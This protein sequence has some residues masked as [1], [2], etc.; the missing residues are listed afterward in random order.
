[1]KKFQNLPFVLTLLILA[2]FSSIAFSQTAFPNSQIAS[3]QMAS[4]SG[5]KSFSQT[6]SPI[7]QI[8]SIGCFCG[9]CKNGQTK[10]IFDILRQ[11]KTLS[12]KE[13]KAIKELSV[14]LLNEL[15]SDKL[16]VERWSEK[17]E[18]SAAVSKYIKD[19]LYLLLP[20]PT[21]A[22]TDIDLKSNLVYQ[23]LRSQYYGGGNSVYGV[24]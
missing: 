1:M 19:N 15:K 3:W 18:T 21:Y 16:K 7:W 8:D 2:S 24:Y 20:Y 23:H 5:N 13:K 12:D 22:E 17:T 4:N 6:A 9:D 14:K 10:A 11:G